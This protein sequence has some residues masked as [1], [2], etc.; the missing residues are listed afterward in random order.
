MTCDNF[1]VRGANPSYQLQLYRAFRRYHPRPKEVLL[2]ATWVSF[3]PVLGRRFEN[4]SAHFPVD[5]FFSELLKPSSWKG[6]LL[7]SRFAG[8]TNARGIL[9]ARLSPSPTGQRFYKGYVPHESRRFNPALR[10]GKPTRPDARLRADFVALLTQWR[11][12]GVRVIAYQPPQ[13]LPLVGV[14][15]AYARDVQETA[16]AHGAIY[17]DY[18]GE[19]RSRLNSDRGRFVDWSHL[20]ERGSR[21]FSEMLAIDVRAQARQAAR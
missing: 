14:R 20:N 12:E 13:Y 21:E 11:A 16:I 4:D 6:M 2:E 10:A 8:L 17:L 19:R 7:R 15:T 3:L 5:L 1:A 9:G 18:N